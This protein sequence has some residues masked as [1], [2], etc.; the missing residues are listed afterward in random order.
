MKTAGFIKFV[1]NALYSGRTDT[2]NS[3]S[4]ALPGRILNRMPFRHKRETKRLNN[5]KTITDTWQKSI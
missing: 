2:K 1:N 4:S 5:C 3:Y